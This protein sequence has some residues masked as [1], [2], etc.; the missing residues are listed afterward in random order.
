MRS[1]YTVHPEGERWL[2]SVSGTPEPHSIHARHHDAIVC[3]RDAAE[4]DLPSRLVILNRDGQVESEREL[5]VDQQQ[6]DLDAEHADERP[7]PVGLRRY[8]A[9]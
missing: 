5:G 7:L 1:I 8:P 3:A 2:V 4:R 9:S 6:A